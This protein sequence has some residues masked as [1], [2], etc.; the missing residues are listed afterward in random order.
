MAKFQ[1]GPPNIGV[2]CKGGMKKSRYISETL[3][4]TAIDTVE[5]E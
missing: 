3:Q 4:D 2:E 1:R 5:C